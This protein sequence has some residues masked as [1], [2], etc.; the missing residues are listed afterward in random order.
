M[1]PATDP[2]AVVDASGKVYGVSGI[3]VVDASIFPAGPRCNLHFPTVAVAEKL[4]EEMRRTVP[5]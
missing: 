1:G 4:A 2:M 5:R 3:R